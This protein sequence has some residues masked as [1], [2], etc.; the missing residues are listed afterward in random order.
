MVWGKLKSHM[1]RAETRRPLIPYTKHV[2]GRPE[3]DLHASQQ[4]QPRHEQRRDP[5]PSLEDGVFLRY[6][7]FS[8]SREAFGCFPPLGHSL[9]S[10]RLYLPYLRMSHWGEMVLED[11]AVSMSCL[12]LPLRGGPTH[13]DPPPCPR[14]S[15]QW[16]SAAHGCGHHTSQRVSRG[17]QGAV[18]QAVPTHMVRTRPSTQAA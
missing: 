2:Q 18:Q 8:D 13:G 9:L 7:S 6:T 17:R 11:H 16:T 15:P 14:W 10:S 3:L 1:Q 12:Q 5:V 4:Q